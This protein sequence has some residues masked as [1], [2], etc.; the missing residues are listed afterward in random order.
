MSSLHLPCRRS[1]RLRSNVPVRSAI[2][3]ARAHDGPALG[4]GL[5]SASALKPTRV[6]P[7][8]GGT[9]HPSGPSG[10]RLRLVLRGGIARLQ[11]LSTQ[12]RATR[13]HGCFP[14]NLCAE[15]GADL[16]SARSRPA[17]GRICAAVPVAGLRVLR[18][19][20]LL[21]LPHRQHCGRNFAGHGQ[22][23]QVRLCSLR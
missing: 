20:H 15:E 11:G 3:F 8:N 7:R 16:P 21:V 13:L 18:V 2:S 19:V 10:P 9:I 5:G 14:S 4:G 12:P 17:T 6:H 23:G 22:L 1:M